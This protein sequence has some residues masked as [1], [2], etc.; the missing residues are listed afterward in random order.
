M[1]E[2]QNGCVYKVIYSGI[3]HPPKYVG[4]SYEDKV[5]Y[6]GYMGSPASKKWASIVKQEMK[7]HPELYTIQILQTTET[8]EEAT[9]L[10][11][12]IQE[13]YNVVKSDE[14][15]NESYAKKNGYWGRALYG[16]ANPNYGNKFSMTEETRLKMSI[17]KRGNKNPQYGKICELSPSFGLKRSSETKQKISDNHVGMTGKNHSEESKEKMSAA[18]KGEKSTNY[19]K[20]GEGTPN[21]GNKHSNESKQK[22]R[23]NH[24]GGPKKGYKYEKVQCPYCELIGSGWRMSSYHFEN[25]KEK[26]VI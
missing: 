2:N 14:Y 8:R 17:N 9:A 3:K 5:L 18:R 7:E 6:E 22:M 16:D 15:W 13:K 24:A 21:Y 20:R 10:E 12:D 4:S 25:C 19:G 11:L 23:E 26:N 1:R